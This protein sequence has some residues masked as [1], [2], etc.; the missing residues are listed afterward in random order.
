MPA[1]PAVQWIATHGVNSLIIFAGAVIL[2]RALRA[3]IGRL[4]HQFR[5]HERDLEWQRRASTLGGLLTRLV[6]V[7]VWSTNAPLSL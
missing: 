2:V 6:T 5:A 4:Q 3:L 1:S 7:T